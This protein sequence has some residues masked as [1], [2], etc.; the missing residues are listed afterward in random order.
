MS[1]IGFGALPFREQIEFFRRKLDLPTNS[2]TDIWN[3][4]HD[5]A[6]VVAGAN[7]TDLVQDFMLAIDKAIADG[8]TLQ[9]FRKD[10]DAIVAKYGWSYNGSRN[11]RSQVIYDTNLRTSYAA[12]RYAQLQAVKKTMPYWQ[13]VH[14]DSVIHPRPL[15]KHWGDI[16]LT[17]SADD[18]WWDTHFP[19]NGWGCRC[20]V[21]ALD[22]HDL[23]KMGK[24][25]PDQA[26]P[27]DMRTVTVGVRGPN[28]RTVEV[29]AGIDPGF[30]YAPGKSVFE[31]MLQLALD[32]TATL[33]AEAAALSADE[34]LSLPGSLE[35]LERG[36]AEFLATIDQRATTNATYAV[37]AL[38]SKIVSELEKLGIDPVT[39]EIVARD[40]ELVHALRILKAGAQTASGLPKAIT[41]DELA[42]LPMVIG[43]PQAV[44]FDAHDNTLLYIFGADRRE[45]GKIAVRVNMRLKTSDG[46]I[47]TNSFRTASLINWNDVRKEIADGS[48]LLLEGEL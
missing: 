6:F 25:G 46:K 9:Q 1:D 38:T 17:L 37:G 39:A 31:R 29:P 27:V 10:F 33:P 15:H 21:R 14:N 24:S 19:P 12:G 32:K 45:A 36:F 28:P 3:E 11:W 13:Y 7:R 4:A 40:V 2:W 44:L 8:T 16:K 20:S 18:P 23:A 41:V 22:A 35:S 34:F 30:G 42:Q 47:T 43:N 5:F 26:P 48:L